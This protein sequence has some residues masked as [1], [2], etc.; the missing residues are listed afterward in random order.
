MSLIVAN[1]KTSLSLDHGAIKKRDR[2]I[3]IDQVAVAALDSKKWERQ[4]YGSDREGAACA[5]LYRSVA[6][7]MSEHDSRILQC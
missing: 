7:I 4:K 1:R 5:M 6:I 2:R 3:H